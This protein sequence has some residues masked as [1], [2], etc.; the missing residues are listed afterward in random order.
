MSLRNTIFGKL[1][2]NL[3]GN[4]IPGLYK[5]L[6]GVLAPNGKIYFTARDIDRVLEFNPNTATLEVAA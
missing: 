5:C 6:G 2:L 1:L 3:V 4:S